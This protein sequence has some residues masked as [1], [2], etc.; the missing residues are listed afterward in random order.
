MNE[1]LKA[2]TE[3]LATLKSKG[4]I[5]KHSY[6]L[7]EREF[8]DILDGSDFKAIMYNFMPSKVSTTRTVYDLNIVIVDAASD[9]LGMVESSVQDCTI[10]AKEITKA[11]SFWLD[12]DEVT[13]DARV[14][15]QG[16]SDYFFV[17]VGCTFKI[18]I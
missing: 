10:I 9:D 14:D 1:A 3:V 7:S 11:I 2:F 15:R 5:E 13:I 16:D 4:M 17:A 8:Q 6:V 18:L 12:D